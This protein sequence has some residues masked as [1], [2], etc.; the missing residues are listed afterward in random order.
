MK[1]QTYVDDEL[2]AALDMEHAHLKTDRWD[3]I[4]HH[5][6]MPNKGWTYSGDE[7]SGVEIGSGGNVILKVLGFS[8]IPRTDIFVFNVC[9]KLAISPG[10]SETNIETVSQ[11]ESLTDQVILN[12]RSLLSNVKRIF[13]PAGL[14]APFILPSKLLMRH[15]WSNESRWEWDDDLPDEERQA[16]LNFL[17]LLLCLNKL[18]IPRSLWPVGDVIG[19]PIL[20]IFFNGSMSV[21]GV[22]V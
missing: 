6:G 5:A 3:E 8:W 14:V 7:S 11:L 20:V 2:T 16:W 9:V 4:C 12:R 19:R 22:A 18:S 17:K 10:G 15:T 21:Y 13:D 1:D